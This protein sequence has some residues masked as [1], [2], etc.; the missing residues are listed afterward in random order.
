M[1]NHVDA[2]AS[3]AP[4]PGLGPEFADTL[5]RI[6][7]SEA[8]S[9]PMLLA[10]QA[11]GAITP[12]AYGRLKDA[13][14]DPVEARMT[15]GLCAARTR[16]ASRDGDQDRDA[17]FARDFLPTFVAQYQTARAAGKD[18]LDLLAPDMQTPLSTAVVAVSVA[19]CRLV[20]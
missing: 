13:L 2:L 8:V 5:G 7:R 4:S 11:Q 6:A 20:R 19:D 9:K 17:T 18:P 12:Q 3:G 14:A 15:N 16:L 1:R 10:L